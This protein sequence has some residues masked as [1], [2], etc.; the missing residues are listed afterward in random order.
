MNVT[1]RIEGSQ[2]SLDLRAVNDF[3]RETI[4]R[5][6]ESFPEIMCGIEVERHEYNRNTISSAS[7]TIDFLP[8]QPTPSTN[9]CDVGQ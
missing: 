9:K 2:A 1:L 3:E 7:I 6:K 8:H 5:L 4:A